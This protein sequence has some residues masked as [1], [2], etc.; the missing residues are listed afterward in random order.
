MALPM[1]S[2]APRCAGCSS[3]AC[4]APLASRH[5]TNFLP[6]R[7]S[8]TGRSATNSEG[9]IG[10]H[11]SF[12]PTARTASTGSLAVVLIDYS[13]EGKRTVG[14]GSQTRDFLSVVFF[15]PDAIVV[16]AAGTGAIQ[17][18]HR[19]RTRAQWNRPADLHTGSAHDDAPDAD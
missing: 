12:N 10:Y 11:K 13:P 18:R 4:S 3:S 16:R 7:R 1:D 9:Q 2:A 8:D 6:R 15:S 5:N 19:R 14:L 17:M